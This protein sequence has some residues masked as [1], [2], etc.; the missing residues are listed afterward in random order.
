MA[1]I[2]APMIPNPMKPIVLPMSYLL[3]IVNGDSQLGNIM[4]VQLVNYFSW[5]SAKT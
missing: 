2:G 4:Q 5:A 3:L 1:A